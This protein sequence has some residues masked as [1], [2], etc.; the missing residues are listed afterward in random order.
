KEVEYNASTASQDNGTGLSSKSKMFKEYYR[1]I[2]MKTASLFCAACKAGAMEADARG[3][4][5]NILGEYG[6]EI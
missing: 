6:R 4:I 3:E 1:I 2:N 5:L